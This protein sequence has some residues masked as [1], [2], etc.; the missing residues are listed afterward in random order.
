MQEYTTPIKGAFT[1]GLM[2][3]AEA[4]RADFAQEYKFAKA[5]E[6]GLRP[7]TSITVRSAIDVF[8]LPQLIRGRY[9]TFLAGD[10]YVSSVTESTWVAT[11][12]KTGFTATDVWH[13]V[14]MGTT[15]LLI[16]NGVVVYKRNKLG[17]FGVA[18]SVELS[19]SISIN[20]GCAFKGRMIL[21]GFNPDNY[22]SASWKGILSELTQQFPFAIDT[23]MEAAT[24]C[25]AWSTI[26]GGDIFDLFDAESAIDGYIAEDE[27]QELQDSL[28]LERWQ[29]NEL[30][31]RPMPFQGTVQ[32]VRPLGDYLVVYGADG[33]VMMKAESSPTPTFSQRKVLNSGI[34]S[35]GAASGEDVQHLCVLDDG[36]LA[37]VSAEGVQTIG[38]RDYIAELLDYNIVVTYNPRDKEYFIAGHN[39]DGDALSFCLTK[40]GL[41]R[42][43]THVTSVSYSSQTLNAIANTDSA[44]EV[45]Y[46]TDVID[47]GY[48]ELKTINA[49]EVSGVIGTGATMYVAFDYRNSNNVDWS[50]TEWVKCNALGYAY[51]RISGVEFR[52]CVKV[53]TYSELAL[54][55]IN[56]KV[57]STAK[58]TVRGIY[59]ATTGSGSDSGTLE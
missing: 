15:W 44:T 40:S 14:D 12:I 55:T 59:A 20:T 45:L 22:W 50:R 13:L 30:G 16:N 28:L 3:Q 34:P 2:P 19:T 31:I 10:D 52:V 53:T 33:I 7:P 42:I 24:N 37:V 29:R 11:V 9:M 38:Y 39:T 4:I 58:R 43:P 56:V 17:M 47:F 6:F 26:G 35:R 36:E 23:T 25:V 27:R 48:R 1:K 46:T 8:P 41:S 54:D 57:Q 51:R 32:Q 21:A 5:T 49:A 18:D